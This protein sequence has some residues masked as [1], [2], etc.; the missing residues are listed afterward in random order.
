MPAALRIH[1]IAALSVVTRVGDEVSGLPM[2]P[3]DSNRLHFY[4]LAVD[5]VLELLDFE[6][7]VVDDAFHQIADRHHAH[8]FVTNHDDGKCR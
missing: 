8:Q 1:S 5:K 2:W 4:M 7:L 3:A 6:L